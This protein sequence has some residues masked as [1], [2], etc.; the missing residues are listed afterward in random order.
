[1]ETTPR[2]DR[3]VKG[4]DRTLQKRVVAC[5]LDVARLA[6]PRVRGKALTANH[7]GQWRYRVGAYRIIVTIDYNRHVILALTVAHRSTAY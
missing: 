1:V 3:D 5:L 6:D 7:R 2:F 4:L